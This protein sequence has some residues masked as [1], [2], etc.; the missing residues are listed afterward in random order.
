VRKRASTASQE[1]QSYD[2]YV[3]SFLP[4]SEK[5]SLVA[6]DDPAA[7]GID[8]ANL[9]LKKLERLLAR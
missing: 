7:F 5:I 2:D 4:E 6:T 9:S 3:R 1:F 8:L